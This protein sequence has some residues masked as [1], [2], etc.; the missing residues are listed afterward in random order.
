MVFFVCETCNETLKR[1]KVEA[2]LQRCWSAGMTC[3]DCNTTFDIQSYF[4]HATCISEAEKYEGA[5]PKTTKKDV[6][7]EAVARAG[8][9]APASLRPYIARLGDN[10]PRNGKKF[11]NFAKNS[12][13][14]RNEGLSKQLFAH[15]M[16]TR[17][18][19]DAKRKRDDQE[20]A[21]P[22]KKAKVDETD[23]ASNEKTDDASS[24]KEKK[25]KK[26][27]DPEPASSEEPPPKKKKKKKKDVKND[28]SSEDMPPPPKEK[29]KKKKKKTTEEQPREAV[30]TER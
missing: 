5:R 9:N 15:L 11:R 8:E 2:H 21:P 24:K 17:E 19:L 7:S 12:L 18:G 28:P 13:N 26:K 6:W 27:K 14:L 30:A 4:S 23:A 25:K 10:V 16:K 29:K 3:V 22:V 1:G 20:E